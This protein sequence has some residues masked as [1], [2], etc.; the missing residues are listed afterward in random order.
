MFA[1]HPYA[2][3]SWAG[4]RWATIVPAPTVIFWPADWCPAPGPTRTQVL[5]VDIVDMGDGYRHRSTKGFKPVK[6][7]WGYSFP[8]KS[9]DQLNAMDT[10]L[11]THAARGFWFMHP[12]LLDPTMVVANSWSAQISDRTGK[13]DM[14]GTLQVQFMRTYNAQPLTRL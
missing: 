5:E 14:V 10:F 11:Q 13:G 6:Q 3:W 12:E 8:F 2:S 7:E 4:G 1:Q 9:A